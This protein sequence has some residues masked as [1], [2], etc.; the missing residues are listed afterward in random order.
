MKKQLRVIFSGRVQ[1]VGFRFTAQ[2]AAHRLGVA[3]WV[4]N[5]PGGGVEILVEAEETVLQDFLAE[6]EEHFRGYILD[7]QVEWGSPS[8]TLRDFGIRM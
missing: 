1:G 3:G 4:R 6:I 2:S 8:G 5:E 7:R